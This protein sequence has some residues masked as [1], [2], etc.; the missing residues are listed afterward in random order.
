M[1][2][3]VLQLCT[4]NCVLVGNTILLGLQTA[5]D[6][7]SLPSF[8]D[9]R[10]DHFRTIRC[11]TMYGADPKRNQSQYN[12]CQRFALFVAEDLYTSIA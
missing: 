9:V 6:L 3:P 2:T 7:D 1:Y 10:S 5:P 11:D 4:A 8:T 12:D